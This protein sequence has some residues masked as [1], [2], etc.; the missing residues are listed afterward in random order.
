MG[1]SG[2]RPMQVSIFAP[3]N[4]PYLPMIVGLGDSGEGGSNGIGPGE[5]NT[6]YIRLQCTYLIGRIFLS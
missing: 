1:D 5:I 3:S 6:L 4:A 2:V